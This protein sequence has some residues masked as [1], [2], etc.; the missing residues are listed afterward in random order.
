MR[1]FNVVVVDGNGSHT[2]QFN[3]F[4]WDMQAAIDETIRSLPYNNAGV[5]SVTLSVTIFTNSLRSALRFAR[6]FA[7]L[8]AF[9]IT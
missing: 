4:G 7:C 3:T 6:Y 5:L 9:V 2:K 8:S 1:V